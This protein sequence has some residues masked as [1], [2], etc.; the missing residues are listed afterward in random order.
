[1][2]LREELPQ[3][4]QEHPFSRINHDL[5][6][7]ISIQVEQ[8]LKSGGRISE[9]PRGASGIKQEG[10]AFYVNE[11]GDLVSIR[12]DQ[13]AKR[14]IGKGEKTEFVPE[15]LKSRSRKKSRGASGHLNV[16]VQKSGGFLVMVGRKRVGIFKT[17]DEAVAARN[18]YYD[19]IGLIK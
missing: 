12:H 19:K 13:F 18:E 5:H 11:S 10:P 17:I 2:T 9:I 14:R 15:N 6:N 1:M 3:R 4:T 8:F 7:E 16:H